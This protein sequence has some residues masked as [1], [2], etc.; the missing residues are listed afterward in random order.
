VSNACT[1]DPTTNLLGYWPMNDAPGST[2]AADS[3]SNHL[4]GN[5][6]GAVA[7]VAGAGKQGTGAASFSGGYI[8]VTFPANARG[9]GSGVSIPQG[10]ITFAMWV[11]SSASTLQ[12]IQVVT[13]NTWGGGCDRIIGNGAAGG[14]QFN[15]WSEQNFSSSTVINDG[16]WHHV[17]YVLDKANGFSAYIDGVLSASDALGTGN[18]GVGCSGFDWASEYLIGTGGNCRFSAN[19]YTGIIDDVR[20]YSVPLTATGVM[21]LYNATK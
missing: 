15:A 10:N 11:K 6:N 17:A 1:F 16:A 14:P 2:T 3:S 20:I 7:F 12:G 21:T 13:G 19:T 4:T 18:C 5:V 8:D 9:D